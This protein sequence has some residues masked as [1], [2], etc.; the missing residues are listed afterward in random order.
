MQIQ[1][2]KQEK[3]RMCISK[4]QL[5]TSMPQNA[6]LYLGHLVTQSSYSVPLIM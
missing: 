1:K 2:H 4:P 6:T 5:V 3:L